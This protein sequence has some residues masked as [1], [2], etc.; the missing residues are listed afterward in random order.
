VAYIKLEGG[1][2]IETD[3]P[4]HRKEDERL[5]VKAG[6]AAMRE[7][8][9]TKLREILKP[10]DTVYCVLRS[11]SRSGMSRQID[12][13]AEGMEYL[14]GYV[15]EA[16]DYPRHRCGPLK[17]GGCGMDMGFSVVY[18]LGAV[19]WPNGTPEPHGRRNGDPDSSGGYA[20]KHRWL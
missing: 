16:C 6:K 13:Y 3:N 12:F 4:E 8:A 7:Q 19:L 14:T 5:T 17:V 9:R 20:L 11:V 18:N 10:G 1:L 15:S 2:I